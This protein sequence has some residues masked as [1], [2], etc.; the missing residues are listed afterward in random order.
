MNPSGRSKK[1]RRTFVRGAIL[2]AAASAALVLALSHGTRAIEWMENRTYDVRARYAARHGHPDPRIVVIDIDEASFDLLKDNFGRWP[3]PRS[4]WGYVIQYVS[5][6]NPKAIG[7]DILMSGKSENPQDDEKLTNAI[8]QSGKVV[9]AYQLSSS[10]IERNA[11]A[12]EEENR[13]W[14]LLAGEAAPESP[15]Q[16]GEEVRRQTHALNVPLDQLAKSAAGLGCTMGT[17]DFEG[18]FRRTPLEIVDGKN[19]YRSFS[20]RVADLASGTPH[21]AGRLTAHGFACAAGKE[22]PVDPRGRMLIAWQGDRDAYPRLPLWQVICS[23][24]PSHCAENKVYYPPDYFRDKIVLL[25]ASLA[26]SAD[27]HP[28]P[29]NEKTPGILVHAAAIDGLLNGRAMRVPPV[30]L[31]PLLVIIFAAAGASILV[32]RY[33][34]V[35]GTITFLVIVFGYAAVNVG[36]FMSSQLSL[37][38]V[39]PLMAMAISYVSTG[40]IR[41]STTGRDLR[42][43]RGVLERYVAPQLVGYVMDHLENVDFA[44]E[45]R[46]LTIL[47]SD[48]RNFTTLTEQSDPQELITLLNEYL[49]AMTEIIFKHE[50]I[51]DKFIGDGI[52]AHWGAFTPGKNHAELACRAALEMLVR[53]AELNKKWTAEGRTSIAI[54]V[55]I[56]TGDVIF[57]NV[58]SGKK[59]E[60]TVIGDPVNL[61]ARLEG[62]NK[63]FKTSIII[64]E[65]TLAHVADVA[66]TRPLGGVKVK[67]KTIETAVFELQ[68]LKEPV[69]ATSASAP[70]G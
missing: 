45:K 9:L 16:P 52:L 5:R 39:A 40:A 23:M 48:V 4:V 15:G 65:F 55:G 29:I 53:V 20:V 25:G 11:A 37:P 34:A 24:Q 38:M 6:G 1:S 27:L 21:Q 14:A 64:S 35:T 60:F 28:T 61:A 67:G 59:I 51:V 8:A 13:R 50:G 63:D 30:W 2:A 44:G 70:Q 56:N 31:T 3:W 68:G 69:R 57:G 10:E 62:L 22:I 33:S 54:G 47:F 41:Y 32:R 43:T 7:V 36:F 19:A 26:G 12:D 42:K 58:G 49:A 46:E 66:T 17:A 18:S